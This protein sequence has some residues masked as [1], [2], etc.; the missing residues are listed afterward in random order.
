MQNLKQKYS[1]IIA[2]TQKDIEYIYLKKI[3]SIKTDVIL[4]NAN[5]STNSFTEENEVEEEENPFYKRDAT[6]K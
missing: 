2:K 6:R 4:I 1:W 5:K 3:E